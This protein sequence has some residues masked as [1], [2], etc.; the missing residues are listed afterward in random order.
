MTDHINRYESLLT[1]LRVLP[2]DQAERAEYLGRIEGELRQHGAEMI[3][4]AATLL[5]KERKEVEAMTK[6]S[7]QVPFIFL[8]VLLIIMVYLTRFLAQQIV[9][10]LNRFVNYSLRIAQ[11]DFT[12]IKPAKRYKDEFSKLA[13]AINWMM[14]QLQKNQEQLI[15]SRKMASIGTLTSGIAHELN[16]PLNNICITA[17][18]LIDDFES[19]PDSEKTKRIRDIYTQAERASGTVRNL[20]DFTRMGQ[21]AFVSLSAH[22]VLRSVLNLARNEMELNNVELSYSPDESPKARMEGDF[23]QLQQCFLN[24]V[25]N[26]IQAMPRGGKL[27]LHVST[28]GSQFVRVDIEDTGVGIPQSVIGQ[29]F[30]PFFTTREKGTGLGLST[31]Y[32]IAKKHGGKILV[33][34][35]INQGSV[36]SVLIPKSKE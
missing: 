8:A 21:P 5:D 9:R 11:G 3:F 17:E 19:I 4:M 2:S 13:V 34:S 16:N 31:S 18:S 15:Q 22:E 24:L 33:E 10:P 23:S 6:L 35:Q 29:I 32:S 7:S 26:A 36:F 14:D 27:G 30:D 12:P 1:K 20:L 25:I 28:D